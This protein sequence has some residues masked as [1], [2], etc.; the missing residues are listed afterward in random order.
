LAD[1]SSA[2]ATKVAVIVELQVNSFFEFAVRSVIKPLKG[3]GLHVVH[4]TSNEVI[5]D[6]WL[7]FFV[8]LY[9][10]SSLCVGLYRASLSW[11]SRAWVGPDL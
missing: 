3:W 7:V 4:A 6:I 8:T 2:Q 11:P 9:Y 5:I 10:F 1:E